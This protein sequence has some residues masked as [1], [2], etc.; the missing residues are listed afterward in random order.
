MKVVQKNPKRDYVEL[1]ADPDSDWT[2]APDEEFLNQVNEWVQQNELGY[3]TSYNGWKLRGPS[4]VVL[5]FLKW[6]EN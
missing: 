3:R 2:F 5:F 1:W 4:S 6:N